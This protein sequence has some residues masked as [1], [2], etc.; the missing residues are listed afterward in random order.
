MLASSPSQS[1]E[2]LLF[3]ENRLAVDD[4]VLLTSTNRQES[5]VTDGYWEIIPRVIVRELNDDLAYDFRYQPSYQHFFTESNINGVDHNARGSLDWSVSPADAV[6]VS[7]TLFSNRRLRLVDSEG[8]VGSAALPLEPSD[9]Q[10]LR[11]G[12]ARTYYRRSLSRLWSVRLDYAY[13]DIHFSRRNFTDSSAQTA[14]VGLDHQY[15]A[16]TILGMT[17]TNR[18]RRSKVNQ[19]RTDGGVFREIRTLSRTIDVALR[20]QRQLL[21]SLSISV[22]AGPSLI[23]TEQEVQIAGPGFPTQRSYSNNTSVFAAVSLAREWQNGGVL[24]AGYSRY[25]SGGGGQV[26]SSIVDGVTLDFQYPIDRRWDVRVEADWNQREEVANVSVVGDQKNMRWGVAL[27][28]G[29]QLDSRLKLIGRVRYRNQRI[30]VQGQ[31]DPET[32]ITSAFLAI[33][34]NFEKIVF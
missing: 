21:K 19:L 30:A 3:V 10:R 7:G 14:S 4:N 25:E 15:D 16:R 28:V 24:R 26:S 20:I 11:R 9:G 23:D 2:L 18:F 22:Q 8:G 6:G 32:D 29:H 33:Q 34:Y 17:V 13:D 12:T 5:T 27:T 31:E 1:R